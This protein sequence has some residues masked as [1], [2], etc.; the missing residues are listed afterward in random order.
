MALW[1]IAIGVAYIAARLSWQ[2]VLLNDLRTRLGKVED[3]ISQLRSDGDDLPPQLM[4]IESDVQDLAR[5]FDDFA[6]TSDA[7]PAS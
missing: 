6:G 1:I 3:G 4:A 7:D 5:R 2:G